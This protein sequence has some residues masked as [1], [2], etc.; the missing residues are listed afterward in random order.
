MDIYTIENGEAWY[1][2]HYDTCG[3]VRVSGWYSLVA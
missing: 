3:G 1:S 2:T